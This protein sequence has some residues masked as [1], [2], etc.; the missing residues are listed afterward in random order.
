VGAIAAYADRLGLLVADVRTL[1]ARSLT[2]RVTG[3]DARVLL[4]GLGGVH[5]IQRVPKNDTRGR[6]QTS[7][8]TVALL[9]DSAPA[10]VILR[11]ADLRIDRMRG[12][13]AGGQRRNKVETAVRVT[14]F[15]SGIVVT[16]LSGRSQAAN[17][18]DAKRELVARLQGRAAAQ[19]LDATAAARRAQIG[20]AG[21]AG[22][23]F[24]HCWYRDEVVRHSD[25]RRWTVRQWDQ[26]RLG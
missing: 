4:D 21:R 13:G 9:S 20:E 10:A 12:S 7:T 19:S 5:R 26:G 22:K 16:R 24:T 6:K 25:G 1:D 18:E 3:K 2:F 23:D 11:P 14:H 15:P 8:A 17:I